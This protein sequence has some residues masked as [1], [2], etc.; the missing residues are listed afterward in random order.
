VRR[1][2]R[3]LPAVAL[4]SLVA[5]GGC[6]G[7][8]AVAGPATVVL[9]GDSILF[10][11]K[12]DVTT[13]LRRDGWT[14]HID[15]VS[16]TA[17]TGGFGVDSWPKRIEALVRDLRPN[18]VVVELGT[19]GCECGHVSE[20]IDAVM[21]SLRSVRRVYWINVRQDAPSPENPPAMNDAI[22]DAQERWSN[23]H[24]IDF[25]ERFADH[26]EWMRDGLHPNA[27]G[28]QEIATLIA[29]SLPVV[30]SRANT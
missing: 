5:L 20:G 10:G 28:N 7:R 8:A 22:D 1:P 14:V 19:N 16:G 26:R 4:V 15:A 13:V 12:E 17:I 25:N 2:T 9:V 27:R 18:V 30:R 3:R 11:A 23:L 21:Q 24:V 29:E 6:S